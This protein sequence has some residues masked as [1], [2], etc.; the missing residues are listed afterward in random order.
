MFLVVSVFLQSIRFRIG[1][2]NEVINIKTNIIVAVE[3]GVCTFININF[4]KSKGPSTNPWGPGSSYVEDS[5]KTA[6]RDLPVR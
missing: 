1:R 5:F 6:S 4:K 2:K 3:W